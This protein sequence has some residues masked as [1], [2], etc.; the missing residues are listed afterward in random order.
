MSEN[1]ILPSADCGNQD[2]EE[3]GKHAP[4]NLVA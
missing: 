4:V 1:E 3:L 2:V